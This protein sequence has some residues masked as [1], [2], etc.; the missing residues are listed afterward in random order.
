M[1]EHE[2]RTVGIQVG[3]RLE[4]DGVGGLDKETADPRTGIQKKVTW[5]GGPEQELGGETAVC[6]QAAVS[7]KARQ[8]SRKDQP[9]DPRPKTN[10]SKDFLH[11]FH[12]KCFRHW[13][14]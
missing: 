6:P 9:S 5:A 4:V 2:P 13:Q 14:A 3:G 8:R 10:D 12:Q 1:G 7:W 11:C